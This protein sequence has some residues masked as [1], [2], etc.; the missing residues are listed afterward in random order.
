MALTRLHLCAKQ[1]N[2][3]HWNYNLLDIGCRTMDLKPLLAECYKYYG[4]DLLPPVEGVFQCN[5]E[6]KLP[7]NDQQFDVV[8]ALDILEHLNNPHDALQEL[9][10][11]SKKPLISHYPICFIFHS[12]CASY[13]VVAFQENIL[14]MLI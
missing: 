14:F 5:L 13:L 8:T 7:F 6:N 10:R 9:Y 12:A 11:V 3:R 1:I 2:K 4:T